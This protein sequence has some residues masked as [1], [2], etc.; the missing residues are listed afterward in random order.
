MEG[1]DDARGEVVE[2]SQ[3]G[4]QLRLSEL[5]EMVALSYVSSLSVQVEG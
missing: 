1:R 2:P 3:V 4:I 5:G